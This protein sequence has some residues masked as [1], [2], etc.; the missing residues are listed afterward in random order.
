MKG[1]GGVDA[2]DGTESQDHKVIERERRRLSAAMGYPV[3]G[4]SIGR[5]D[6][7]KPL[8]CRMGRKHQGPHI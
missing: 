6:D 8:L 2:D 4:A 7:G 3:C 1:R 5:R